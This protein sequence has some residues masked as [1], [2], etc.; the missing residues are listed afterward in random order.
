[1]TPA[2]AI[3]HLDAALA[4][5]GEDVELRRMTGTS[6]QVAFSATCRAHVRGYKPEELVGA[7]TQGDSMVIL[8]PTDIERAQ[9]PGGQEPDGPGDRRV[10][11]KGDKVMVQGRLRNVEAAAPKYMAGTLVRIEMQVRG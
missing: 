10:P 1:M 4:R 8:S 9:W 5:R 6:Q 11:R 7:I 2:Q 3:A